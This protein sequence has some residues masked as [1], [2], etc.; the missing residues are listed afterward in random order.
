MI[1]RHPGL[2]AG[3]G[4]VCGAALPGAPLDKEAVGDAAE[5]SQD[6]YSIITLHPAT[7]IVVGDV[8]ALVQAAFDAPTLAVEQQPEHGR[9]QCG[10]SAAD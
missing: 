10:R 6:P 2:E 9:Q 8:Q 3:G 5:H 1:F 4:D 7:V